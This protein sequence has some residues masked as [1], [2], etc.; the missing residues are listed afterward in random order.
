MPR[1]VSSLASLKKSLKKSTSGAS[2]LKNVPEDGITVRF[3]TEPDEWWEFEEFFDEDKEHMVVLGDGEEAPNGARLSRRYLVNALDTDS[4]D[5]IPLK[6]PVTASNDVMAFYEKYGTILDRDYEISREGVKKNTKYHVMPEEKAA[7]KLSRYTL[8]DLEETLE[9]AIAEG[10]DE[11]PKKKAKTSTRRAVKVA[12]T[13]TR[14]KVAS[15]TSS[16][17]ARRR[18]RRR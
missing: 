16:A 11:D 14:P 5:V 8:L 6:L 15:K 18:T 10:N 9:A 4:D 12:P 13:P 7:R 3:L 2:F 1:K 17:P